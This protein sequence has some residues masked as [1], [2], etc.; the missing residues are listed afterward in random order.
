VIVLACASGNLAQAPAGSPSPASSQTPATIASS[1]PELISMVQLLA[2][3]QK[4]HGRRVQVIGF[5][6]FEFEGNAIYL[7]KED[8][9]YGITKNGLWLSTS[10]DNGDPRE[11]NNSYLVVEGTINAEMKGHMGLWSGAIENITTLRRWAKR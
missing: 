3:P 10:K 2:D 6:H 4:F 7:S 8:Y 11:L 5:A 1:Q 9:D